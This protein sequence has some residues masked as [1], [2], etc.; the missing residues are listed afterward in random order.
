MQINAR[1]GAF[2]ALDQYFRNGVFISDALERF[3]EELSEKDFALAY[4]IAAGVVR[5]KNALDALAKK[6]AVLPK[7]RMEKI[8]LRMCLYQ[9]AF[10]RPHS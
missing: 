4:E 3:K 8:V 9:L 7:K 10:F 5:R 2:L 6:H 1:T